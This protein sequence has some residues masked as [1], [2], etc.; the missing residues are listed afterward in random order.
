V[1]V[2]WSSARGTNR[3]LGR[4]GARLLLSSVLVS[5]AAPSAAQNVPP[6]V[7]PPTREQ[8]TRPPPPPPPPVAPRLEV[9][10]GV[11]RAPCALDSPQF[12]DIHLVVRNVEFEGLQGLTPA[13]LSSAY[14]PYVGHDQPISVV[15]EIRDRAA[16]ILRNAGYIAAVQV[17]EQ[18]IA[19]GVVR[20]R[21]LMAH[22]TQVRVR[23]D[24]TGA[25]RIIAGYLNQLTKE[26]VFNRYEAERYL[27]L[28]SDLPG[29]NVRL[30]L[31]PAEGAPGDVVGDV[32][33]QRTPAYVDFNV[34]NGGSEQLG[35][36]GGLLRAQL[37]GL[38]GLGDRTIFS[39]FSTAD[40]HEQQTVQLGHDFRLGPQGLSI[41]GLFTYAWARPDIAHADVFA[42]T[43]LGTLE[44][45]YPF[46]RRQAESMRGSV[47][48][49]YVDQDVSLDH[50]PLTRDR[51]RVAFARFGIDA[52]STNFSDPRYSFEEPR[53]RLTTLL[54]LRQGLDIF[55]ASRFCATNGL[56]CGA[57][58]VP[59]SREEAHSTATVF[60]FSAYG[61]YRPI[62]KL[63]FALGTRAQYAWDPLLSF[64]EFSTGNYTVGRGYDPGALLGDRGFGTQAEIRFGS[65]IPESARKPGVEGY[66]FWDHARVLNL[67]R[68][69]VIT[70][71][72]SLNSIGGGARA[73]FDRFALDA[74]LAVPLNRVGLESHKPDPRFLISLTTRLWPWSFR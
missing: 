19:D 18:Q 7:L 66:V 51:L 57:G 74:A 58:H 37:F 59:T 5:S 4:A 21:V 47:G 9:E 68:S 55:G 32:S 52:V 49:D 12:R 50:I 24:A 40:F 70:G 54:E 62:P 45:A 71:H 1:S 28:A 65:R 56:A 26:P 73:N 17:P 27:L 41:S 67:D 35:P 33:V 48:M 14:V 10:G 22:L 44:V 30:T 31:R 29:Y 38:T 34:E 63:T 42:R 20:F 61:E 25:E 6:P 39:V 2:F 43:L 72:Q 53:W 15:C 13:Q 8:V 69:L 46:V 64:E 16:T 60:R 36:W 3:S 23:G 11:E